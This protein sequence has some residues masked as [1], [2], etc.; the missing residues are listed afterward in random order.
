MIITKR[1]Q[2]YIDAMIPSYLAAPLS[3]DPRIAEWQRITRE[4]WQDS[5]FE[6]ILSD[7]VLGEISLGNKA[8][9]ASRLNI[10]AGLTTVVVEDF[11]RA[12]AQQLVVQA[13][14]PQKAFTD[15]V[16]IAVCALH[17]IPYLATWNLAHIANPRTKPKI[18]L[19]CRNAGYSPPCIDT[20]QTIME[21]LS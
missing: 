8:K 1:H 9:A 5:R 6:F 14:M 16:H 3:R 11:D 7:Y 18:E 21:E 10:V 2:V 20:P 19:A 12:F 17:D 4:F 13:A 15:A